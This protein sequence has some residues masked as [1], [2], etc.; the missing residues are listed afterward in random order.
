MNVWL[1]SEKRQN[2]GIVEMLGLLDIQATQSAFDELMVLAENTSL[3]DLYSDNF[4]AG[5]YLIQE[6]VLS[7]GLVSPNFVP[8]EPK[9]PNEDLQCE[10]RKL[11]KRTDPQFQ[12]PT[13]RGLILSIIEKMDMENKTD[14]VVQSK[15]K[16][17]PRL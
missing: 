2:E 4:L 7:A 9:L 10:I 6:G 17:G 15:R 12:D 1:G 3:R 13:F 11:L 14:S 16:L 5:L 8:F